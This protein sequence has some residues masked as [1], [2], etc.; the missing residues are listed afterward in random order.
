MPTA[1][2]RR[3]TGSMPDAYD[4]WLVPVM[5]RPY[6]VELA[7]R[8]AALKPARLLEVA[9]GTGAATKELLEA[10][11]D[12]AVT[13]T[14]LNPAMVERG[15]SQA[16][17]ASWQQADALDLPFP[18]A[19]FDLVVCQFGV[20]F[21]PDKPAAFREARRVLTADGHLL[22]TAWDA[23]QA[24]AFAA[25]L[26]SSL[27]R[28]FRENPPTF[29]AAVPHGYSDLAIITT[30]LAAAGMKVMVAETLILPGRAESAADFARGLC[31]GSPLRF[32]LE[33]RGD[34]DQTTEMIAEDM[35]AHLGPGPVTGRL[36]AHV[37]DAAPMTT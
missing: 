10:L 19:E 35:E 17:R 20:M 31:K 30:D 28:V 32:A 26:V 12:A 8:A 2:D 9:A 7:Q 14:D 25:A 18:D 33:A 15:S 21:F 16:P 1:D 4:R 13:A 11:P 37:V 27:E 34:L 22:F 3:W 23:V 5:F 36:A 6:A 29:V 24:N